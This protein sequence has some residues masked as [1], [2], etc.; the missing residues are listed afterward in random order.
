MLREIINLVE[1]SKL[2][3]YLL[4]LSI[5]TLILLEYRKIYNNLNNPR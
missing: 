4:V 1:T 5:L 2:N 3:N